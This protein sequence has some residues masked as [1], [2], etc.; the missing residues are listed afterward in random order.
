MQWSF[1]WLP[2]KEYYNVACLGKFDHFPLA[3]LQRRDTDSEYSND[4]QKPVAN[5]GTVFVIC[6]FENDSRIMK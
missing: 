3:Q 5:G 4:L 2:S 1:R 6:R